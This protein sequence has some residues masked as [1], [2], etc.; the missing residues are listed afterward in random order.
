MERLCPEGVCVTC[1]TAAIS[2]QQFKCL[3][4]ES[5]KQW[6]KALSNLEQ[7]PNN[8][9]SPS[10]AL[11]A[12]I[13][14]IDVSVHIFKDYRNKNANF[15]V[16]DVKSRIIEDL[17]VGRIKRKL[18]TIRSSVPN[19]RSDCPDCGKHFSS[20]Y[21]L[22]IHLRNSGQKEACLV[23][24]LVFFRGKEIKE[25][26]ASEHNEIVY[27]CKDCPQFFSM[28]S[29]LKRHQKEAH[30]PNVFSCSDC[31][32]V[33]P[34]KS[35]FEVHSQ[36][37]AVRTCRSC[38]S[39]FT[40][41]SC[42][43]Q[44]RSVCEPDAKPPRFIVPKKK[45]SNLRDLAVYTCDYCSKT[46]TSRPQLKNHIIWIHMDVRPHQCQWCGKRFYTSARLAEHTV[47][48]TRER[49]FG[50]DICGARLVSKMA[51][52]YH[53]RRHTGEKPYECADC[54]EKF[55]SSSRRTEHAKKKA[56]LWKKV[57]L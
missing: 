41:R 46:Y 19:V 3:I 34:R 10:K 4:Q 26:L 18:K 55:I 40:N 21:Y 50:C 54:G 20:P 49:N 39:Q 25:H 22:N 7:I 56:W 5:H 27:S 6:S 52:I 37:H 8:V 51:A 45:R 2:A 13:R 57:S 32:R 11:C 31:G 43:R 1:V 29:D 14:G 35:S 33:F 30:N 24:G 47:V 44:H 9:P 42:Y 36:M 38:G 48:H 17:D 28:E 53:R 23:C 12:F 16:E 15:T